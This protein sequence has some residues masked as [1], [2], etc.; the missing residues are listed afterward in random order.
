MKRKA[1]RSR[2]PQAALSGCL[3]LDSRVNGKRSCRPAAATRSRPGRRLGIR[4]QDSRIEYG[5]RTC[6]PD[7]PAGNSTAWGVRV[8]TP[9]RAP[10]G[11]ATRVE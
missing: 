1:I 7:A 8:L 9:E 11:D 2:I 10:E 6:L 3:L 4:K 5:V